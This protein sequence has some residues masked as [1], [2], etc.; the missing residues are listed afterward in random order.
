MLDIRSRFAIV[1]SMLAPAEAHAPFVPHLR[2]FVERLLVDRGSYYAPDYQELDA[3]ALQLTF[4][5]DGVSVPASEPAPALV[6]DGGRRIDRD[7]EGEARARY[8]LESLGALE[9]ACADHVD[10]PVGSRADYVVQL[11]D[12]VHAVCGFGAYALPQLRSR[13]WHIETDE[14][15]RW[16]VLDADAPWYASLE[17]QEQ[18]DWFSL[19]LGVEIDG[20]RINLLPALLELLQSSSSLERLLDKHQRCVAIPLDARRYLALPRQRLR[21]LAQVLMELYGDHACGPHGLRLSAADVGRLARLDQAFAGEGRR[22]RRALRWHGATAELQHARALSAS[23]DPVATPGGLQAQLRPYQEQGVSW[24]Q[25]LTRNDVG[26]ILADD[27]GLGKTLQTIAHLLLE[28][29]SSR[30]RHPSL[31]VVPTSLVGNWRRE[32]ARFAPGLW[33][34]PYHGARRRDSWRLV[35]RSDVV[36]TTYPILARDRERLASQPFHLLVLDEAQMIKNNRSQIHRAVRAMSGGYRLCLTGTPLENHLGEL[37]SLFEFLMPG[38][39]GDRQYFGEHYR[40]PIENGGDADRLVALRQRVAPYILRRTKDQV[41][42]ELPPKT[43]IIRAVE[44]H[45]AQRELYE[46]IRIAAHSQVRHAI[47]ERGMA[48]STVAI[49]DALMK[50]RQVCCDP[51]LVRME[52]ARG[53]QESAKLELLFELLPRQLEQGRRIL[54]FSQ[55]TSMLALI[56]DQ[57]R[58]QDIRHVVLTGA[59]VNRQQPIDAFN[60]GLADVFLISLKAGGTGLNLTRADTVIHYDPWWNPAAQTQATDRAHRIGQVR[61]VFAYNLIVAHSVEQRMLQLQRRKQALAQGLLGGSAGL[62]QLLGQ[63]VDS[64]FRPLGQARGD[65]TGDDT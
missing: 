35:P 8:L 18:A 56:G 57:L 40:Q 7:L 46:S 41:A 62:G 9:L 59:T 33:V 27:M 3:P 64:L 55:F 31:V 45:G 49:L 12:D 43:E 29:T 65:D 60:A 1:D 15:Y 36:L 11:D 50:L 2:L 39:L 17:P 14:D 42:R 16:Q 61:P 28:H 30:A 4:D 21:I 20:Q 32:L 6:T 54:L 19:E 47:A 22:E 34:T 58:E 38:M 53:V 37:W 13:G 48:R 51:R 24:L 23:P 52:A 63:E 26:G 5:Y 44:L 10:P 25:H